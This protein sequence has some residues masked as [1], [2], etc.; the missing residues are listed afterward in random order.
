[1]RYESFCVKPDQHLQRFDLV[2]M[3]HASVKSRSHSKKLIDQGLAQV[4]QSV[5]K[6]SHQV[7][8]GDEISL[9]LPEAETMSFEAQQGELEILY[10]DEALLVVNKA[11]NLV[12]H[13]SAGHSAGT[14]VNF[15]LSHCKSL[16]D[17]DP[18]RPGIVHR[19]DQGTSGALVVAKTNE[20]HQHLANQFFH[21]TITRRYLALVIGEPSAPKGT[22]HAPLGRHSKKRKTMAITDTG[23][24][25]ITHWKILERWHSFLTLLE[26]TLETGRTHQVRVHLKS[27]G[28]PILGDQLYGK[29]HFKLPKMPSLQQRLCI[30]SFSR[31]ALH[32]KEL[33][34]TH[35]LTHQTIQ[36]LAPL[37]QDLQDLFKHLGLMQNLSLNKA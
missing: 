13:H 26:C 7:Q 34:F 2:L 36:C 3:Q 11:P 10:E 1:M 18:M 16:S 29:K 8:T 27:Q 32:A 33:T 14:L 24:D 9:A 4:N 28:L 21:H 6:C 23:K 37:P 22:I 20:A 12:V 25:A 17:L 19:L 31:Q 5:V 15:L 35:P 30:S